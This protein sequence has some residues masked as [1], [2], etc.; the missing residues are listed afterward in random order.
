MADARFVEQDTESLTVRNQ[1]MEGIDRSRSTGVGIR[2]TRPDQDQ[3][4]YVIEVF[5]G[6]PA[7]SAGVKPGDQIMA[8]DNQSTNGRS[9]TE[10]VTAIRGNTGTKVVLSVARGGQPPVDIQ[11]T[12]GEMERAARGTMSD[13]E[14][15]PQ[16]V[17]SEA[18][19]A[20]LRELMPE[21]AQR[22]QPG[23]RPAQILSLFSVRTF[24]NLV[25]AKRQGRTA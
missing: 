16:G 21:A 5:R 25:L 8:V 22:I 17:I 1:E 12:R 20:R 23:L 4:P 9:L 10:I 2:V 18:G 14:F 24:V 15:A 11:I 6:S 7:E 3:P 13:E 19:L